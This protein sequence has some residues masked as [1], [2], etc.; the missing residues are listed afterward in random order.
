VSNVTFWQ[1]ITALRQAGNLSLMPQGDVWRVTRNFGNGIF[2]ANAVEAGAFLIQPLMANYTRSVSYGPN[3]NG[4]ENFTIT[5][6]MISEPKIRLAQSAGQFRLTKAVDSNGNDLIG[7]NF[8]QTFGIGQN[9]FHISAQLAYPKNPGEKIAE[10]SGAVKLNIARQV[11]SFSIDDFGPTSKPL[12][13]QIEGAK[14]TISPG[15]PVAGQPN[16]VAVTVV[17]ETQGDASLLNRLQA[18]LRQLRVMDSAGRVLQM[19]QFQANSVT[20]Q[21]GEYRLSF[22]PMG[23]VANA[24]PYKLTFE[25]PTS[26]REI[27]VPISVHDLK[28][29]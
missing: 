10:I 4:G 25:F 2:G 17:V 1:A 23:N 26:Y 12:E 29:P 28:M 19:N 20:A 3:A 5:F 24:G 7:P 13:R 27:E 22:M 21:R 8:M 15:D 16:W 14:I 6:Q 11:E 18:P 9:L